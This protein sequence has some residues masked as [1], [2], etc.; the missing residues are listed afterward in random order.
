[1]QDAAPRR[2]ALQREKTYCNS[3]CNVIRL[4]QLG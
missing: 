2:A 3:I 4:L 1:M